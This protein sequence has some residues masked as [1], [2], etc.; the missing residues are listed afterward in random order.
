[1]QYGVTA[2]AL[3]PW[4]SGAARPV[5]RH[6]VLA[7]PASPS[8]SRS[9]RARPPRGRGRGDGAGPRPLASGPPCARRAG[10]RLDGSRLLFREPLVQAA[11][12]SRRTP[13]RRRDRRTRSLPSRAPASTSRPPRGRGCGV[14]QDVAG[15]GRDRGDAAAERGQVPAV[16]SPVKRKSWRGDRGQA[17]RVDDVDAAL[18][19]ARAPGPGRAARRVAGGE[20]RGDGQRAHAERLAVR[21]APHAATAGKRMNAAPSAY[22]GSSGV[23]P[24]RGDGAR[25]RRAGRHRRAARALQGRDPARVIEVGVRVHDEAARPRCGSRACGC[26]RR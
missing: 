17:V 23:G 21:D 12:P 2:A 3:R 16:A 25:A 8:R 10:S 26:W 11:R 1:M 20:V 13:G 15:Q 22:W 4:R 18:L 19:L 24:A 6:A 5:A 7:G 14:E 9:E